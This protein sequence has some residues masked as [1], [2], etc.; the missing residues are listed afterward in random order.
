MCGILER[1]T[2]VDTVYLYRITVVYDHWC[3]VAFIKNNS[4]EYLSV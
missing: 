4:D 1:G 2:R 3:L